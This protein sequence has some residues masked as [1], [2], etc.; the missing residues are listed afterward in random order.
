MCL[1]ELGVDLILNITNFQIK[2]A[3]VF[4]F[5]VIHYVSKNINFHI[6]VVR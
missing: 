2:F 1:C 5:L 6:L 4:F 3:R